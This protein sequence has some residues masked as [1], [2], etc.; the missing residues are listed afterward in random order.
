MFSFSVMQSTFCFPNVKI[1]AVPTTCLIHNFWHLRA[2]DPILIGKMHVEDVCWNIR[3][4][5][6]MNF[7]FQNAFYCHVCHRSLCVISQLV[8]QQAIC[9]ERKYYFQPAT[10]TFH[11]I[12][13]GWFYFYQG[14]YFPQK[15]RGSP[16]QINREYNKPP[17][18]DNDVAHV[19]R[20][21]VTSFLLQQSQRRGQNLAGQ[22][23]CQF[24]FK[25]ST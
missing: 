22:I 25:Q 13:K 16:Y 17:I 24:V 21:I 3:N 20:P 14:H 12:E 19:T 11:Y 10:K 23:C 6:L 18:L 4:V 2:V 15:S 8:C 1:L 5:K 9:R 7:V